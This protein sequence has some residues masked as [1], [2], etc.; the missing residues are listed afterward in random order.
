MIEF[1][2]PLSITFGFSKAHRPDLKQFLYG[3][4]VNQEGIPFYGNPED[5]YMNDKTWNNELLEKYKQIEKV[6]PELSKNKPLY[7]ADSAL[8]TPTNLRL[9]EGH[10][11]AEHG[12]A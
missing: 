6:T 10:G 11:F 8:I 7:V 9:M 1:Y 5:G 2:F 4:I 3:L 12:E